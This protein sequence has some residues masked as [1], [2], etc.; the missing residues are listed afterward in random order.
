MLLLG[1]A[2][3]AAGKHSSSRCLPEVSRIASAPEGFDMPCRT[4]RSWR[5]LLSCAGFFNRASARQPSSKLPKARL[6]SRSQERL[7]EGPFINHSPFQ[8]DRRNSS[9]PS[10]CQ[11]PHRRLHQLLLPTSTSRQGRGPETPAQGGPPEVPGG[12]DVLPSHRGD[13]HPPLHSFVLEWL[14]WAS[15]MGSDILAKYSIEL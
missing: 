10:P 8:R 13:A 11:H 1:S 4:L 9:I 5:R 6:C 3:G 2:R 7:C 12:M 14:Q 15:T